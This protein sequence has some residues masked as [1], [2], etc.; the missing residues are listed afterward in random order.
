MLYEVNTTHCILLHFK[1]EAKT[2]FLED[3][4]ISA[5]HVPFQIIFLLVLHMQIVA[6]PQMGERW[7]LNEVAPQTAWWRQVKETSSQQMAKSKE[8]AFDHKEN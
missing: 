4:Y 6:T 2:L 8:F 1:I 5:S 3:D 7:L